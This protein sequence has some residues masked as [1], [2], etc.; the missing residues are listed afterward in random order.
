MEGEIAFNAVLARFSSIE[1]TDDE[2]HWRPSFTL[3]GLLDLPV[4]VSAR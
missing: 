1:L 3:R 2:A 4:R